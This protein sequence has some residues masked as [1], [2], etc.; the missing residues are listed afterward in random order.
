MANKT[1]FD[2]N[3][4]ELLIDSNRE[5]LKKLLRKRLKVRRDTREKKHQEELFDPSKPAKGKINVKPKNKE[6]DQW[7]LDLY[8]TLAPKKSVE[9]NKYLL[10]DEALASAK[11][12]FNVWTQPTDFGVEETKDRVTYVRKD[13]TDYNLKGLNQW[14]N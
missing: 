1:V 11:A 10:H 8:G 3:V 13:N 5:E 12:R 14:T 6:N 4:D 7:A 2:F 9:T